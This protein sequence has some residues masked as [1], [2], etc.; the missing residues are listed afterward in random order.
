MIRG[1]FF[2]AINQSIAAG[3]LIAAVI[4]ARLLLKNAP[5]N[6]YCVLWL[7]VGIRLVMPFSVVSVFSLI[8]SGVQVQSNIAEFTGYG[9][10]D[11]S[12]NQTALD[13]VPASD[14]GHMD[15]EAAEAGKTAARESVHRPYVYFS[16][17][18]VIW[19]AG[20]GAML[21]YFM[22]SWVRIVN[23][24]RFAIPAK[25]EGIKYYQCDSIAAPFLF[26]FFKTRIYVPSDLSEESF[27]YV[28]KH[29]V[30]HRQRRD[31]LIKP[32]GYL[33]LAVYWFN[34]LMWAAYILLC[35][36]I[37]LACD[38][39][40]LKELGG[41]HK[42]E[43][44]LALLSCSVNHRTIA[45]C[46]V[47]FGETGV[48]GRIKNVLNY[49]KPT[50]W[51][52]AV[53]VVV[54]AAVAVCFM[55][56]KVETDTAQNNGGTRF[57][58][59]NPANPQGTN[60]G[61]AVSGQQP[62]DAFRE[63]TSDTINQQEQPAKNNAEFEDELK[64]KQD[65]LDQK[66]EELDAEITA[67]QEELAVTEDDIQRE[68][69]KQKLVQLEE[70]LAQL[71]EEKEAVLLQR[72]ALNGEEATVDYGSVKQWAQAFCGRDGRTIIEMADEAVINDMSDALGL[73]RGVNDNDEPYA[74]FGWSSPWPWSGE[75][76]PVN[77]RILSA[78]DK[79]AVIL[80]YAWVSDPHVTVWRE[81]LSYTVKDGEFQVTSQH[82]DF[83][84][85]ICVAEEF[86]QAYPDG[87]INGTPMDYYAYNGA[88]EA[89]NDN[90]KNP[91]MA[92]AYG[93]LDAPDT[94]AVRLLNLLNNENKVAADVEYVN[95]EKTEAV[96]TF[97]FLE[98]ASTAKVRMI[99]PYG[100]DSIWLPQT[101]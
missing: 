99:K 49:K 18:S 41:E 97:T 2:D 96:V 40:V 84:E 79:D 73:E 87:I 54:V 60:K 82:I 66:Q 19:L 72:N 69:L 86:Y 46:P 52:I 88:G 20:I 100:E 9:I 33:F 17:A 26:G 59:K 61:S 63:E 15:K 29:E 32:I 7:L 50:F 44:A 5:K 28:L 64:A 101:Y 36:D 89:L 85:G 76:E 77:Y 57:V 16:I 1:L 56:E 78:T 94:A 70:E 81:D 27:S 95:E 25:R 91:N 11:K 39:R 62:K 83:L 24:V 74:A 48:K 90:A 71:E 80:Y 31:Y 43:Y 37:E 38:E 12:N 22:I 68:L 42:K 93:G 47:A 4:L 55:T 10:Q 98:N 75:E 35:R 6:V 13:S 23:R 21:F 58:M 3:Y 53:T 34:P 67:L 14:I 51:V 65:E 8:P 45:A 30:V 92:G